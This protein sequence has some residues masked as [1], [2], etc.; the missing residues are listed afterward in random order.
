MVKSDTVMNT[1]TTGKVTTLGCATMLVTV[2]MLLV[3]EA[4]VTHPVVLDRNVAES[5]ET[6]VDSTVI[7][8]YEVA[9][10]VLEYVVIEVAVFC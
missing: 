3:K 9:V 2:A 6:V 4:C 1:V 7:N 5:V 8:V 10:V